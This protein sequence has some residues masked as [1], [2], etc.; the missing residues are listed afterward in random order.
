MTPEGKFNTNQVRGR[1]K[2]LSKG[3]GE[4]RKERGQIEEGWIQ[5]MKGRKRKKK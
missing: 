4:G 3:E 5:K 2:G 1:T